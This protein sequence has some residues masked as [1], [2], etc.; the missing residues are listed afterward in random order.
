MIEKIAFDYKRVTKGDINDYVFDNYGNEYI[1]FK[2]DN[3]IMWFKKLEDN[4]Y[5]TFNKKGEM[6]NSK[7]VFL[8]IEHKNDIKKY[9][10]LVRKLSDGQ[11]KVF[12]LKIFIV[13]VL[14]IAFFTSCDNKETTIENN[15][16]R[17]KSF[18]YKGHYYIRFIER[19]GAYDD[20]CGYV[21]D[22]DCKKCFEMFD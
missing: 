12:Y 13:C 3:S 21:H 14:A 2:T 8:H 19:R 15:S 4:D 6:L 9:K 7:E 22:P 17:A 1:H 18:V 16:I 11:N 10:Y 5:Y 20:C